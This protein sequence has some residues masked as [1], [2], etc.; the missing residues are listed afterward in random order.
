MDAERAKEQR[1]HLYKT[2]ETINNFRLSNTQLFDKSILSLSSAGLGLSLAFISNIVP[3]DVEKDPVIYIGLLYV[4]WGLFVLAIASTVLSFRT[5]LQELEKQFETIRCKLSGQNES[6]YESNDDVAFY[7]N[8]KY[9]AICSFIS[10]ILAVSLT[11]LFIIINLS[12]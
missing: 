7:R 11:V 10:Y 1:E 4:S 8:T 12:N 9:L 3:M 2:I 6:R 5:G